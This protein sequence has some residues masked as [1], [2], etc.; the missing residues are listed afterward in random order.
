MLAACVTK[1]A[2]TSALRP[3]VVARPSICA[4]ASF[5]TFWSRSPP[6]RP[7]GVEAP[8]WVPGAIAA[9]GADSRMKAPADAAR[10]PLGDT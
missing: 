9:T 4:V 8:T 3:Y 6:D 7:I 5:L 2:A 1:V 10:A